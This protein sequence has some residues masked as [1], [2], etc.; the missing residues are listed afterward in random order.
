M[1]E[2]QARDV[3]FGFGMYTSA[4]CKPARGRT[5]DSKGLHEA[6]ACVNGRPERGSEAGPRVGFEARRD[7]ARCCDGNPIRLL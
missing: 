4:E 1:L 5:G 3:C 7:Q 6:F 2:L